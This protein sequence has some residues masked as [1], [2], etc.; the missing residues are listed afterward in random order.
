MISLS[1]SFSFSFYMYTRTHT[2]TYIYTYNYNYSLMGRVYQPTNMTGGHHI[3]FQ[4]EVVRG[5]G[6]WDGR[7]GR[8]KYVE[9]Q[10]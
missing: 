8:V 7:A 9:V 5:A 3:Q 1:L 10:L 4:R 2:Y 6:E